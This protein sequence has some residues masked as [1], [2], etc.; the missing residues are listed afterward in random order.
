MACTLILLHRLGP[1]ARIRRCFPDGL[2]QEKA[3][4]TQKQKIG[5]FELKR[6]TDGCCF[7]LHYGI[8]L[9]TRG[10]GGIAAR[11]GTEFKELFFCWLQRGRKGNWA[12]F[13]PRNS[14]T[15]QFVTKSTQCQE[16]APNNQNLRTLVNNIFT[17]N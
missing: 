8:V 5:H 17:I 6:E 12:N 14:P 15:V 9:W 16:K 11:S 10:E 3:Y 13:V 7:L 1:R 2:S 4:C